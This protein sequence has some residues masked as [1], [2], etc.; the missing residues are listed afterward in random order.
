MA[1]KL[2]SGAT[3]GKM[4]PMDLTGYYDTVN[5][6]IERRNKEAYYRALAEEAERQKREAEKMQSA[7]ALAVETAKGVLGIGKEMGKEVVG[8]AA[9]VGQGLIDVIRPWKDPNQSINVFGREFRTPAGAGTAAG[10]RFAEGDIKG[11][12]GELLSG[13]IDIVS[14]LYT[15]ALGVRV[16]KGGRIVKGTLEAAQTAAVY[17]GGYGLSEGLKKG[18]DIKGTLKEGAKGSATG[19]AG[20]LVLGGGTAMLGKTFAK[21]EVYKTNPEKVIEVIGE[22]KTLDDFVATRPDLSIQQVKTLGKDLDGNKPQARFEWDNKNNRGV[23][24]M[25]PEANDLTLAH[26]VGHYIDRIYPDVLGRNIDEI[27]TLTGGKQNINEDF[28]L[29]VAQVLSNEDARS[30]APGLTKDLNEIV[31]I[32]LP[33]KEVAVGKVEEIKP[34]TIKAKSEKVDPLYKEAR[35]YKS[36]EEFV[37]AD[38]EKSNQT[39]LYQDIRNLAKRV[40]SVDKVDEA[41]INEFGTD[42]IIT[43]YRGTNPNLRPS[44]FESDASGLGK[45]WSPNK[46]HSE[47]FVRQTGKM[48]EVKIKASELLKSRLKGE[49]SL[50]SGEIQLH[51]S[52]QKGAIES[53]TKSQLI[54]IWNKANKKTIETKISDKAKESKSLISKLSGKK[55]QGTTPKNKVK[56]EGLNWNSINTSEKTAEIIDT[57]FKENNQFKDVR[58]SRS[59]QDIIEGARMVGIDVNNKQELDAILKNMPNANTAQKLK[60]SMVDS[61]NDLMNY[62]R[63]IDTGTLTQEQANKVKDKFLRTQYIAKTF[64][65][66]RTESSHLLRSM[67]IEAMEGENMAEM[68]VKLKEIMGESTDVSS[69]MVKSQKLIQPTKLD[70]VQAIWYNAILSGWKTWSRNMLDTA[71]SLIAET[72]SKGANPAT[73]KDAPVMIAGLIKGFPKSISKAFRVLSGK[74]EFFNKMEY[75]QMAPYFKNKKLNFW[76]TEVSGRLLA[77]QDALFHSTAKSALDGIKTFSD[78]MKEAGI[79]ELDAVALNDAMNKQL[80]DRIT[81]RNKP[82]GNVGG[83]VEGISA[84]TKR[85]KPLKFIIPFT[86]VVANVTDRKIDY[87]P[88]LNLARTVGKKYIQQEA[89]I[90]LKSTNISPLKYDKIRPVVEKRLKDQQLGRMF[91]GTLFSVG[92][93]ALAKQGNISGGG[94]SN[95]NQVKQLKETGWRP[96]SV[97]IGDT[98]IPYNY[99]GPLSGILAGSG[100]IHDAIKYDRKEEKTMTLVANGL[101]GFSQSLLTN[102]FLS[103]VSDLFE[104]LSGRGLKPTDY[105]RNLIVNTLPIPAIW[106]QTAGA[107]DGKTYDIQTFG[108]ALSYKLGMTKNLTPRLNALGEEIRSDFIYGITPAKE[109]RELQTKLESRGLKVNVPAKNTKI[110]D[111]EMTREELFRYTKIRGDLFKQRAD[112]IL[113]V[114]DSLPNKEIKEK[115]FDSFVRNISDEAKYYLIQ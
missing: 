84:V 49:T 55:L 48:Y 67:G 82:L 23:I 92:A 32:E 59:N 45:F 71:N 86:K 103:G 56:T 98:W 80:A 94:P 44:V 104:V 81:Y 17:G 76:A 91:L 66:L 95:P 20:G 11:G 77:A 93:Y 107:L 72:V 68:A 101:F 87:L 10:Q 69:F 5:K 15:P 26:E 37:K 73:I 1:M 83:V 64:S 19:F 7:R 4:K 21:K 43:L 111:R 31:K 85:V 96:Y 113:D 16:F 105:L 62:L 57:I 28:A 74:E 99:F 14:T 114:V 63:T 6:N 12:A 41:I 42:P 8:Q 109:R 89:D 34:K 24:L 52:L 112:Y 100:S 40:K 51:S 88:I 97:K 50:P 13:A 115:V 2:M 25:T 33:T 38:F 65:G 53:K 29:A 102:S 79:S 36:A 27:N 39:T 60:Q 30:I 54:D 22:K 108:E 47:I 58:P 75:A 90:I 70:T 9:A 106:T 110:Q 46:S 61:A 18:E 78:K 3:T 35:K